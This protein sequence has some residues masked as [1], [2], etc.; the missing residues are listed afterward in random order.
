MS[1]CARRAVPDT[2][3]GIRAA[4]RERQRQRE[5]SEAEQ[6]LHR[7]RGTEAEPDEDVRLLEW[8]YRRSLTTIETNARRLRRKNTKALRIAIEQSKREAVEVAMEAAQLT[9]IKSER[10][11]E[12]RWLKGLINLA[13]DYDGDDNSSSDDSVDSPPAADY[14]SYAGHM[15]GKEPTRKR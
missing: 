13:D 14:Y 6:S 15:K 1:A 4:R 7:H 5:R 9:K 10:D 3:A 12:V 8:V 11:R 2:H